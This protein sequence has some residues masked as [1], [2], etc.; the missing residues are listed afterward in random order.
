VTAVG[1]AAS[2]CGGLV[3]GLAYYAGIV[4]TAHASDL[5]LAPSQLLVVPVGG[6]GGLIGSLLDS[7]MGASLQFS[8]RDVKT[9][10]I[11]EVARE[12]VVP[13]A[14]NMLLDNH[15]VNLVSTILTA[16]ILPKVALVMGL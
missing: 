2:L 5:A 15:S 14:G 6:A 1:L 13:I 16:L 11:V 4:L 8:G 12:G 7:I 3:V 10:R 9:G